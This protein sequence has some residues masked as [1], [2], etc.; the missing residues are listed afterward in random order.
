MKQKICITVDKQILEII[1]DLSN[2][3]KRPR[4]EIM[5]FFI[6][7][8]LRDYEEYHKRLTQQKKQ[9]YDIVDRIIDEAIRKI[10]GDHNEDKD[11][12]NDQA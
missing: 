9:I 1:D 3:I 8:G 5:E 10:M 4:S 11:N 6:R 7:K 12:G 2:Q